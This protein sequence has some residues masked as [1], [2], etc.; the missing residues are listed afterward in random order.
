MV[1]QELFRFVSKDLSDEEYREWC[2]KYREAELSLEDREKKIEEVVDVIESDLVLLGATGKL[3][4]V[5]S[6]SIDL[7]CD[8]NQS[9]LTGAIHYTRF[10]MLQFLANSSV[11]EVICSPGPSRIIGKIY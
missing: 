2:M 4:N 10:F 8:V 5:F 1:I 11:F 9:F 3:Q 6:F 7:C